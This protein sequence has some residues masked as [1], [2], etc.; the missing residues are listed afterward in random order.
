MFV[1]VNGSTETQDNGMRDT[2]S[3]KDLRYVGAFTIRNEQT[4]EFDN[5]A[6]CT[7]CEVVST[8]FLH[9]PQILPPV[10]PFLYFRPLFGEAA[11]L[12]PRAC[13]EG[14]S[15][16]CP[17]GSRLNKCSP[18]SSLHISAMRKRS[19]GV[20]RP[21]RAEIAFHALRQC[22]SL[23][24]QDANLDEVCGSPPGGNGSPNSGSVRTTVLV[25]DRKSVV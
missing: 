6:A 4:D 20:R 18:S 25:I 14:D 12:A 3:I 5:E 17:L 1:H 10:L 13:T 8:L 15:S 19:R 22:L 16:C 9:S 24:Y 21:D 23:A 2:C 11:V 7:V